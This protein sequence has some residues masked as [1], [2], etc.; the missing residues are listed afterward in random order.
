MRLRNNPKALDTLKENDKFV[1]MEPS[2]YKGKWLTV[3]DNDNPIHIEIGMGKGDF[4]YQLATQNPD[5]NY[6]GL[7]KYPSVLA[8]AVNKV[9]SLGCLPNVRF[10]SF[11]AISLQDIFITNEVSQIYLNFSDP[12]PK[13]KHEKRRLTS[14]TFLPIY[15]DILKEEGHIE[16]KT[17]NRGLFEFSLVSFNAYK[18]PLLYISLDLHNSEE[19][20]GNIMSEYE[21]KFCQKGPI[22]KA[23]VRF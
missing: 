4:I 6:I 11:D 12:W 7:E 15:Q 20:E 1:I 13:N 16:F 10:I 14:H 8:T 5:I 22:Y 21:R 3:F 17:D 23:V 18:M 9:N 2:L 19:K